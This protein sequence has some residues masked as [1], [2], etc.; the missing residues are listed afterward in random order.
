MPSYPS[1]IDLHYQINP[2]QRLDYF[3]EVHPDDSNGSKKTF[4]A[5]LRLVQRIIIIINKQ[6]NFNL[7]SHNYML[8]HKEIT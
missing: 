8:K 3:P 2:F 1:S 6:K 4:I 5:R 7:M